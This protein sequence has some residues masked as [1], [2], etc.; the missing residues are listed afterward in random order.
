MRKPTFFIVKKAV[1]L[2]VHAQKVSD[3]SNIIFRTSLIE[4]EHLNFGFERTNI[5]PKKPLLNL[6]NYS[7]N[8]LEHHIFEH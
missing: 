4:L 1:K 5:K 7:S 3:R 2:I 8:R 6:L